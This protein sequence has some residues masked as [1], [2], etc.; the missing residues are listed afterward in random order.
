MRKG[1]LAVVGTGI[2]STG[3]LTPAARR[4][5]ER[6]Q[7][8][9]YLVTEP[10]TEASLRAL[11][12]Q[13]ESL[14]SLYGRG[15]H[16]LKTYAAMV[17][18]IME[19]VRTGKRVCFALYGHPGVFATAAHAAVRIARSEGYQATMLPGV[20]AEGCL[21]ADLGIDPAAN[22]WVTFEATDFLLRRRKAD[23]SVGLVLWQV[24]VL[25]QFDAATGAI[26]RRG[27]KVLADE[28][29]K[30]YPRGHRGVLYEASSLP[31]FPPVIDEVALEKLHLAELSRITTLYLP[32][33]EIAPLDE[34]MVRRLG[35]KAKDRIRCLQ[36]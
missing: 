27:L 33:S 16:R 25:G 14:Q 21:I 36:E 10:L 7:Q 29:L 1:T 26:N 15:K 9:F 19:A 12:P 35:I 11:N 23:P 17:D 2:E 18:R 22:G 32:P 6:A 31:G 20:S 4:E 5:I 30:L 34:R 13:S 3:Q 24:G 8:V 28:L